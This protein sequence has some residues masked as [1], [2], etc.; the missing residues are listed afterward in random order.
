[1]AS[2]PKFVIYKDSA[3]KFRFRLQ[4]RNGEP[5]LA[6]QGYASKAGCTNGIESVR[7][8]AIND[9]NFERKTAKNGK[10]FFNL[11]ANNKQ[12]IGTSEMYNSTSSRENG[13]KA[14]MRVAQT[15]PVDEE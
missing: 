9:E 3:D 14:V 15:A 12:V 7:T 2:N 13:V 8:N 10:H 11:L 6:S 4:A 1:M 5:I